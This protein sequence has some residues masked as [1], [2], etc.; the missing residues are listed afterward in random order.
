MMNLR[1]MMGEAFCY[2]WGGKRKRSLKK[3]V[4]DHHGIHTRYVFLI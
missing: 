1:R 4:G 3:G 2:E